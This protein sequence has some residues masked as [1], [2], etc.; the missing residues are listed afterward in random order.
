MTLLGASSVRH[1]C[2]FLELTGLDQFI[3]ASY[4]SQQKVSAQMEEAV[5]KFGEQET[6]R[7]TKGMET[8]EITVCQ[9]ET[10]HPET[11]LVAIEPVS[12]PALFTSNLF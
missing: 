1:I 3:G 4:G 7:L 11:C 6:A 10:F 8:K 5:I 12:N 9:D 2:Q